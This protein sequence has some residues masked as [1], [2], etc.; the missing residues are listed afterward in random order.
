VTVFGVPVLQVSAVIAI[1]R[2]VRGGFRARCDAE[3]HTKGV[4]ASSGAVP[5][6]PL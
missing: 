6:R 1:V 2:I 5:E 3:Q 4:A